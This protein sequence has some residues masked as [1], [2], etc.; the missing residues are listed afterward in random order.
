MKS[1]RSVAFV[2][3]VSLL[4]ASEMALAGTGG[5]FLD[6]FK[7][8]LVGTL[9]GTLGTVIGLAGLIYGLVSGI[10][11]GSL[12]GLGIGAGLAAGSYYGPAIISSM[13]T[14]TLTILR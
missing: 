10:G 7:Q 5:T 12:G 8:F 1:S 2:V 14:L 13:S 4:L 3:F 11:R 6:G 9:E